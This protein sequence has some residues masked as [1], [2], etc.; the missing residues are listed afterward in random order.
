[1]TPRA[2][3]LSTV[4]RTARFADEP[5][6]Q[7]GVQLPVPM[8]EKPQERAQQDGYADAQGKSAA[9]DPA[10]KAYMTL[11]S[12]T[13]CL[14]ILWLDLETNQSSDN[15]YLVLAACGLHW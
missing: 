2:S 15:T 5:V 6:P 12:C 10:C 8:L 9:I 1:M 4:G 13:S 3:R 7:Q 11:K 14:I